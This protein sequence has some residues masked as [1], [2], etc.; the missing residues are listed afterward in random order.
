MRTGQYE[1]DG[2]KRVE[3]AVVGKHAVDDDLRSGKAPMPRIGAFGI[4]NGRLGERRSIPRRSVF[5]H[6][7]QTI[8]TRT[9]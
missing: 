1:E 6:A 2:V 7:A 8:N 3:Q 5:T 4:R 9:P